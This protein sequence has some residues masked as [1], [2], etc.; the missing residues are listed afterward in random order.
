MSECLFVFLCCRGMN[1]PL[2]QGATLPSPHDSWER[3]QLTDQLDLQHKQTHMFVPPY[4]LL[5][6]SRRHVRGQLQ[7]DGPLRRRHEGAVPG[8]PLLTPQGQP[9]AGQQDCAVFHQRRGD[10]VGLL[11]GESVGAGETPRNLRRQVCKGA[12][13][14]PSLCRVFQT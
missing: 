6:S 5:H 8:G 7:S 2:V 12:G 14:K 13:G 4:L 3:L 10:R 9:H 1:W 11:G